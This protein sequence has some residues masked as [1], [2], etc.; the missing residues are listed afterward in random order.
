MEMDSERLSDGKRYRAGT[1][2]R[3]VAYRRPIGDDIGTVSVLVFDRNRR[4]RSCAHYHTVPRRTG[5]DWIALSWPCSVPYHSVA[6]GSTAI[7][8]VS[9]SAS[10]Y[11]CARTYGNNV[12]Q[13]A[14]ASTDKPPAPPSIA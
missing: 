2:S 6:C 13:Y 11:A 9:T 1:I 8:N 4:W 5:I 10:A 14:H 7:S 12:Q 3:M